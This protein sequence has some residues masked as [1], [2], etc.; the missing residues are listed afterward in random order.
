MIKKS[1][2]IYAPA[3]SPKSAG[4]H[5]ILEN[6][7]K[8]ELDS[9]RSDSWLFIG[10]IFYKHLCL[11]RGINF[12]ELDLNQKW[13][14]RIF[15]DFFYFKY[16]FLKNTPILNIISFQNTTPIIRKNDYSLTYLHQAIPFLKNY[17]P[18][19]LKQT[20]IFLIKHFY[21]FFIRAGI[22]T[23]RSFFIIQS[24]W[25]KELASV[26]LNIP[27]KNFFIHKP[28][29]DDFSDKLSKEE[30][31]DFYFYPAIYQSYKNHRNLILAFISCAEDFPEKDFK[32]EITLA[33]LDF[34]KLLSEITKTKTIPNNFFLTNLGIIPREA[35]LN[36]IRSCKALIFPSTI[37][38]YGMPIAEAIFFNTP[39]IASD[40]PYSRELLGNC[41]TYFDANSLTSISK[42]ITSSLIGPPSSNI[43]INTFGFKKIF[44]LY[45]SAIQKS[46][47]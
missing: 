22:T 8:S 1:F 31:S 21:I 26:R 10:N 2:I 32:L 34:N 35:S 23:Q 45:L 19:F 27:L 41:A 37:E 5:S 12:Y 14:K 4:A 33:S 29:P 38:S 44:A 16:K 42:S 24:E 11:E 18:S 28:L 30:R 36:K 47:D 13:L 7:L 9:F 17:N 6:F 15:Y 46:N 39:V 20:K 25:L 40:L 43:L 3:I